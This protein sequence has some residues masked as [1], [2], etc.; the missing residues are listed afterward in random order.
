MNAA[1]APNAAGATWQAVTLGA[2]FAA[3]NGSAIAY[4]G[5]SGGV[6]NA[7]VIVAGSG[8]RVFVRSTAGGT[9]AA[10]AAPF[11]GR[12]VVDVVLDP[13]NSQRFFVTE[14][15]RGFD[16]TDAGATAANWTDLTLT[17]PTGNTRLQSIEFAPTPDGGVV[18]V[19]GNLG[20]SRLP[21]NNP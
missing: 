18:L 10:T 20:V 21:R 16:P 11:P 6:D 8:N 9:L 13:N 17:R 12:T 2:G 3:V 5:R 14:G 4:G 15:T 1:T 7:E 19:G